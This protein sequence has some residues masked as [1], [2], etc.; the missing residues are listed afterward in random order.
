MGAL[1]LREFGLNQVGGIMTGD[2]SFYSKKFINSSHPTPRA[3]KIHF[4]S[5]V[6]ILIT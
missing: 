2:N 5:K 6:P 4:S 1:Q 3:N